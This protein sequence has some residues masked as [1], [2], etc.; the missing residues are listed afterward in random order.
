MIEIFRAA[1][2]NGA[3]DIHI[4]SGDMVRARVHGKLV[5]MTEQRLS[6]D[7]VK[8]LAMKLIPREKDRERIDELFDLDC[9][10]KTL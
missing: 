6:Q 3:S 2:E 1:I 9:S 10:C 5:P 7:Q 4:K 8:D